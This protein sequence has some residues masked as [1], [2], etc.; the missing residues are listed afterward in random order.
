MLNRFLILK[1][2]DESSDINKCAFL[3]IVKEMCLRLEDVH[4]KPA[5]YKWSCVML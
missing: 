4:E 2:S 3:N 5:F 1:D